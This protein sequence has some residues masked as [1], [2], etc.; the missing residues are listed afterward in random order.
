[1][2]MAS[3]GEPQRCH[4]GVPSIISQSIL[5]LILLLWSEGSDFAT[6]QSQAIIAVSGGVSIVLRG[7]LLAGAVPH[8]HTLLPHTTH[9]NA[10]RC[11]S[12]Q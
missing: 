2:Q 4:A 5:K 8:T 12:A 9:H 11:T 1:M 7:S 3:G 10:E 6:L